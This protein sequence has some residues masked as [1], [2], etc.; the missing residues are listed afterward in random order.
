MGGRGRPSRYYEWTDSSESVHV[1]FHTSI[2]D[3]LLSAKLTGRSREDRLELSF[4]NRVLLAV[5]LARSDSCGVVSDMGMAELSRLTGL[6]RD[7]LMYQ[8]RKLELVGC[9]RPFVPGITATTLFGAAPGHH[10][11]NLKH[12]AFGEARRAGVLF[13]YW[14]AEKRFMDSLAHSIWRLARDI[15]GLGEKGTRLDMRIKLARKAIP[16]SATFPEFA[17][18]FTKQFFN[19][20]GV[21]FLQAKLCRYASFILTKHWEALEAPY[22]WAEEVPT[23]AQPAFKSAELAS[24]IEHDC[25]S[26]VTNKGRFLTPQAVKGW[27]SLIEFMTEVAF[28]MASKARSCM[29]SSKIKRLDHPPAPN[30]AFS[31]MEHVI[32]FCA[33]SRATGLVMSIDSYY[34]DGRPGSS[35]CLS[36]NA[37]IGRLKVLDDELKLSDESRLKVGMLVDKKYS[38]PLSHERNRGSNHENHSS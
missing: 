33:G 29:E 7:R 30:I 16:C 1:P 24:W 4:S 3:E 26:F 11:I 34:R 19:G 2:I 18:F 17:K 21:T 13:V 23:K 25:F 38:R 14:T 31:E 32:F 27:S 15:N 9:L 36:L 20:G 12:P 22:S 5:L 6:N 35:M 8:L 28:W 10:Y 37:S